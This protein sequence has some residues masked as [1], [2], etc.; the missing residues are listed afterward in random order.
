MKNAGGSNSWKRC[1]NGKQKIGPGKKKS[2]GVKRRSGQRE[3]LNKRLCV[4]QKDLMFTWR[5]KIAINFDLFVEKE[6]IN[7]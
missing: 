7:W 5:C 6:E 3:R 1:E 4:N 2:V